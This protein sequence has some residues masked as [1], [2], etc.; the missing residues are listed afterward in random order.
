MGLGW[1]SV[2]ALE[3]WEQLARHAG[4]LPPAVEAMGAGG[5]Y[6]WSWRAHLGHHSTAARDLLGVA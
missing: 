3:Q 4:A 2:S 6:H 5:R 1:S